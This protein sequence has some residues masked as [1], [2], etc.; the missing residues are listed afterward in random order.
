M[1]EFIYNLISY[2]AVKIE[3]PEPYG[4]LH[5]AFAFLGFS[6]AVLL[7][8]LLK[9]LGERGNKILFATTGIFLFV[10]EIYKQLY[11]FFIIGGGSYV[12]SAL[13]FHLCSMALYVC[14]AV[15]LLKSQKARQVLYDFLFIYGTLGGLAVYIFPHSVLT[16]H[17]T[18]VIHSL[19]W[20]MLLVFLGVYLLLSGSVSF[21]RDSYKKAT[22]LLFLLCITAFIINCLVFIGAREK[23]SMFFMGPNIPDAIILKDIAE[24]C[25]TLTSSIVCIVALTLGGYLIYMP[26]YKLSKK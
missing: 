4:R 22:F 18:I 16:E 2:T 10:I 24:K 20:H 13:P 21:M 23:I 5:I 19:I 7:A 26:F 1:R 3:R 9:N 12:W 11:Y 14:P 17:L 8:V 25:G 15:V 6:V